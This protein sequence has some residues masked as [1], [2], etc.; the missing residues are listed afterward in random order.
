M[1]A[2]STLLFNG[3]LIYVWLDGSATLQD[4]YREVVGA[5]RAGGIR[6]GVPHLLDL[7]GLKTFD[8]DALQVMQLNLDVSETRTLFGPETLLVIHAPTAISREMAKMMRDFWEGS[9]V[10]LVRIGQDELGSLMILGRRERS[11][12]EIGITPALRRKTRVDQ[13]SS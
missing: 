5:A 3:T 2:G 6:P 13:S 4:G 10:V 11:F 12:A 7:A 9:G 8:P 1:A